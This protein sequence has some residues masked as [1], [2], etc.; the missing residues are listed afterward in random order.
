ML[1]KLRL[2]VET[3]KRLCAVA[4]RDLRPADLEAV[5]ILR[6]GLGLPVPYQTEGEPCDQAPCEVAGV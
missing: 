1:L 4:V 5:A 3:A 2:D 6:K